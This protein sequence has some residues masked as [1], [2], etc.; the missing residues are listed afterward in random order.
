MQHYDAEMKSASTYTAAT[1]TLQGKWAGMQAC[2]DATAPHDTGV[3]T[4]TL[5]VSHTD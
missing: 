1:D 2:S 4:D 5:K 3:D